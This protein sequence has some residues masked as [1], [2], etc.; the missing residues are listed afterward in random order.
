MH[1]LRFCICRTVAV[2]ACL[3]AS[4]ICSAQENPQTPPQPV[5]PPAQAAPAPLPD[6][7]TPAGS[8]DEQQT[9]RI[10]GVLPNFRSVSAGAI[11]PKE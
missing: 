9:R 6:S 5:Q 3:L 7:P 4:G 2:C 1:S 10:M 11:V 8:P